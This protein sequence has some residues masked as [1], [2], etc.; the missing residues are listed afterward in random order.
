MNAK[1]FSGEELLEKIKEPLTYVEQLPKEDRMILVDC[2]RN[3]TN[4]QPKDIVQIT[5]LKLADCI[6]SKEV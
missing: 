3:E 6:E 5:L 4:K 2:L 1:Q